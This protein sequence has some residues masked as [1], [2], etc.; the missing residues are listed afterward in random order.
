MHRHFAPGNAPKELDGQR[1]LAKSLTSGNLME[2][3]AGQTITESIQ[4]SDSDKLDMLLERFD[5][6]DNNLKRLESNQ[7]MLQRQVL[8]MKNNMGM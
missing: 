8:E 4:K 7:S 2:G 1:D 6:L 5:Y 3:Q